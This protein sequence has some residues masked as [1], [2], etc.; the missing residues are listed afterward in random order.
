MRLLISFLSFIISLSILN[1]Q[2]INNSSALP[3]RAI[4][5]YPATFTNEN[6]LAR[7]IDGLGFRFY[8][9]TEG[10]RNEDLKYKNTEDARTSEETIDH[11]LGLT[12][13]IVNCVKN[14]AN[15]NSG[16]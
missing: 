7:M 8:W 4:G 11:I 9:A 13:M 5:D 14:Q 6:L 3:Y 2:E 1:G 15:T 16:S 10:L 12:K